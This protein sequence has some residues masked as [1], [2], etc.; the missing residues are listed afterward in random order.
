MALS[1]TQM[2]SKG[3][4]TFRTYVSA[5]KNPDRPRNGGEDVRFHYGRRRVE[6]LLAFFAAFL[7]AFV[8][9]ELAMDA[10]GYH[11]HGHG[12]PTAIVEEAETHGIE[13]HVHDHD[14]DQ[15]H[16]EDGEG[17][18]GHLFFL[19]SGVIVTSVIAKEIL[20]RVTR[21]KGIRLNSP[22][23]I[24]KA[25]HHRADSISA[26][27]VLLSIFISSY[28][29]AFALINPVTTVVI[30]GLILHSAWEVGRNAVKELIDF[31]PSLVLCRRDS[32]AKSLDFREDGIGRSRPHE[33]VC[34]GVP[35]GRVAFDALDE[36][37][38]LAERIAP[39]RLAGK[40]IEPDLHLI[41]PR[42]IGGGVVNVKSG[43]PCQPSLDLGLLMRG[44]VVDDEMNIEV[45]GDVGLDGAQE[46]K[47]LLV[48][49]TGLALGHHFPGGYVQGGKSG[50][51]CH[52]ACNR[53]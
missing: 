24:A 49:M 1:C 37:R 21:G 50:W 15:E 12:M 28:F 27:A 40:D 25:W 36:L 23:L 35:F 52:G 46:L 29:P 3:S 8:S 10:F 14:H 51:W 45:S 7:L 34:V 41:E 38:H 18:L 42:S 20:F 33:R 13:D 32:F 4:G 16:P 5:L 30:A 48:T 19:V 6:T 11:D 26:L 22:M 2:N 53:A 43:T 17:G 9:V 44:V 31:A 39:N 47:E